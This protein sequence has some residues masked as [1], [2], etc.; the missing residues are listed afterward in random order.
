MPKDKIYQ[1]SRQHL[2]TDVNIASKC[3]QALYAI[4]LRAAKCKTP[5]TVQELVVPSAIEIA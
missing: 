3:L 5:H 1:H 2:K 4:S